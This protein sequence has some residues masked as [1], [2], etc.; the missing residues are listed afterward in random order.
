MP[1]IAPQFRFAPPTANTGDE[2]ANAPTIRSHHSVEAGQSKGWL[3]S[4]DEMFGDKQGLLIG[5]AI[6]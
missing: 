4:L 5:L 6:R 3:A 1:F 2:G